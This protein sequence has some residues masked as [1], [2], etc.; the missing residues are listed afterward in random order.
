[1]KKKTDRFAGLFGIM[2]LLLFQGRAF[3]WGNT[4]MGM[5][6][7]QAVNSAGGRAGA[8]RYNAALQIDNTGYDSDIYFGMLDKAVPDYTFSAGPDIQIFLPWEK[9]VIFEISDSPR[10]VFY[11]KTEKERALN[12][13]LSGNMHIVFDRLY[14]QAGGGLINAKQRLSTELSVNVRYEEE[15]LSGLVLWQATK[16]TSFAVQFRKAKYDFKDLTS[17]PSSISENLNRTETFVNIV[18][19]LE[20]HPRARFYLAGEYGSYRFAESAS[21]FKDS[22]SYGAFGGIEFLPPAAGYEGQTSGRRGSVNLGYKR[23]DI[24]DPLQKDYAGLAGDIRFSLG[25]MKLTAVRL[26]FSRGPQFSVYSGR[27]YYLETSYAAGLSRSL[28]R[29]VLFT[30]DFS[31]LTNQYSAGGTVGGIVL[32]KSSDR[33]KIHSTSLD[34][35]L[36]R[37]LIFRLLADLGKR[38]SM[39]APRPVSNHIFVGFSLTYGRATSRLALPGGPI[40]R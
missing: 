2:L 14:F 11:V 33:Y 38:T 28:T 9:R 18:A 12:N 15:N 16:G 3:A 31:Y 24:L 37:N 21:S 34:I 26:F 4:W 5:I 40:F 30:Y 10:Y 19:Y 29:L 20:Q 39:L 6:L 1:M 8:F 7:E 23:L 25:I 36:K 32:P 27:A 17:E 35:R 13:T 22:R